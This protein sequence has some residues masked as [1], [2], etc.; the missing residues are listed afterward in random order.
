MQFTNEVYW[1]LFDFI[2]AGIL[3]F[4]TSFLLE[5]ILKKVRSAKHKIVFIVLLI[6]FLL[7]VWAELAVGLFGKPYAGS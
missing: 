2:T 1:T 4:L 7:I 5:A 6:A 3:L